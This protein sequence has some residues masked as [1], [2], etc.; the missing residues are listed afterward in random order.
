MKA[1]V[2]ARVS[3]EEQKEAGNSLPGQTHRIEKYFERLNHEII[4]SFSIDESAYKDKRDDFDQV[5]AYVKKFVEKKKEKLLVGF[6][7]V[8][9]LTRNMFDERVSAL[10]QMASLGQIELHF[11]SDAQ[12]VKES[13]SATEK[14]QFGMSISLAKYFSDAISDNVKRSQEQKIRRGEYPTAAPFGYKNV[15]DEGKKRIVPHEYNSLVVKAMF[16]WY[17]SNNFSMSEIVEKLKKEFR[18]EKSKSMVAKILNHKFYI[19]IMTW[20]GTE[21]PHQ[22]EKLIEQRQF[23]KVQQIMHGRTAKTNLFKY[24]GKPAAYRGLFRCHDCGCAMT[25]D[26]K[27][28]KLANGSYN[29][30]AY[31]R[32][33]NYHGVHDRIIN[34]KESEI[35]EQLADLF[36]KLELPPKKLE[37]VTNTLRESHKNKNDFYENRLDYIN[38]EI[39]RYNQRRRKAYEELQ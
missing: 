6:D 1:I 37:A 23:N 38:K 34:V 20:N 16:D 29:E 9:R 24:A 15:G 8:D 26:P 28:R 4:E 10:Y 3:T 32:C 13:G 36:R 19:G 27:K 21:Y 11:V 14:F 30:H 17:E 31:Y 2:I 25:Y 5:V 33:T 18:I 12:V 7:K 22:Y 39:A 35:D